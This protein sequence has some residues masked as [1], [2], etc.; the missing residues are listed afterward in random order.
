MA[1][2][3]PLIAVDIIIENGAFELFLIK[4]KNPPFGWALPGGFVDK[5]ETLAHAAMREAKEETCVDIH[6][7]EFL[8]F[9]S[10]PE[11]DPRGHVVSAVFVAPDATG[12]AKAA[13]DAKEL[14]MFNAER[15]PDM[16]FDHALIL[17]DY[18]HWRKTD[19]KPPVDR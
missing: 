8:G 9:Y 10:N 2:N 18:R 12:V 4:R 11:R 1:P 7:L 14:A 5:G 3:C 19:E 13:D 15:L 6:K 17:S 16:A